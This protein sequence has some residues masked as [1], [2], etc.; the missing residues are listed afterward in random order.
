MKHVEEL[1]GRRYAVIIDEAHSSQTGD[2]AKEMKKVL[3]GGNADPAVS[4]AAQLAAAEAAEASL[5]DE[6]PDPVQDLLAKE[7]DARGK[8]ANMSFFA[9]TATPKGRTLELFG[10]RNPDT[11]KYEPFHLYSMRQAIEEGFIHDVLANYV[12]YDTYFQIDKQISDDPKLDKSR[13]SA[14]IARFVSL[15]EHNLAQRA[16]VIV[17]HFRSHVA[18]KIGGQAKAMVVTA[19]RLHA[20]RYKRALDKYCAEHGIGDVGVLCAFSGTLNDEGE[21][22]TEARVNGFPD[23]ETPQRFDTNDWQILVVAEKYQTG[24]D[25]PKLYAMYVDKT[26]TGLAAVQTLSRL[27]R[28]H[29]Q[30][31]GTFVL[32][33]RNSHEQIQESFGPWY[34]RTHAPPTDPHLLCTTP[35][36][37]SARSMCCTATRSRRWSGCCSPTRRRTISG[38]TP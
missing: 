13:A 33:F 4:Q 19:S 3:G 8:Q 23:S 18:S 5:V 38:S 14:A 16:D 28:T 10:R 21:E 12:T 24:F 9:F 31:T 2:S 27:N 32:D 29:P 1:K 36:P 34:V 20:L 30:K 26:L 35:T 15:H 37:N 22:W 17:N 25:Q 6:V 11:G 7:V